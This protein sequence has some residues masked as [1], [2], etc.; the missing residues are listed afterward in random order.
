MG[1]RRPKRDRGRREG[2]VGG[3][4]G[5]GKTTRFAGSAIRGKMITASRGD[6][7]EG[8]VWRRNLTRL[9]KGALC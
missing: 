7:G 1:G 2:G 3:V 4:G 8:P 9:G 6:R 5:V